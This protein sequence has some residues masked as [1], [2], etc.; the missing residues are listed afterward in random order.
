MYFGEIAYPRGVGGEL[1][2]I[3][4]DSVTTSESKLF[5]FR[6]TVELNGNLV[7]HGRSTTS[8][9][10]LNGIKE[11][12]SFNYCNVDFHCY[13]NNYVCKTYQKIRTVA[14]STFGEKLLNS[15]LSLCALNARKNTCHPE[16]GAKWQRNCGQFDF[17]T[18][19]LT[20]EEKGKT[21]IP[22]TQE[23]GTKDFFKT[24]RFRLKPY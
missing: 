3:W 23:M 13:V 7:R 1:L 15:S 2:R 16:V 8:E 17:P 20:A 5:S 22:P 11:R 9:L 18:S 21:K 24:D 14:I 4:F 10:G 12:S 6:A 19:L